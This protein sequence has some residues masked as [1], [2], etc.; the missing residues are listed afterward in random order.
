MSATLSAGIDSLVLKIKTPME[1][2]GVTPRDDLISAKVWYSTTSGFVPPGAG[3]LAYEGTGL[4]VSITGLT[5]GTDYYVRYALISEIQPETFTL[6]P[7]LTET[8]VYETQTVDLTPP[9]TPTGVVITAGVGTVFIKH[10]NPTYLMGRGHKKTH[11]FGLKSSPAQAAAGYTFANAAANGEIAQFTGNVFNFSSDPSTEWHIWLKWESNNGILSTIPS[12]GT[13]GS[14]AETAV[15]VS[16]LLQALTGEIS[17]SQLTAALSSSVGTI[18]NL[19]NQYTMKINTSG[20][21]AGFGLAGTTSASGNATSDFAV[22]ADK[23]WIAPPAFSSATAPSTNL[24]KGYIW[25]DTSVP[26]T[27]VTKYWTGTAWSLVAQ[28][29]TPFTVVTTP[30]TVGGQ[31]INPGVYIDTAYIKD[32]TITN[33]KIGDATITSAKIGSVDATTIT[34]NQLTSSQINS[35]GLSI[36]DTSGNLLLDASNSQLGVSLFVGTGGNQK[37]LS[38][39]AAYASTPNTAFIGEFAIAPT[40]TSTK[41]FTTYVSTAGVV[42]ITSTA[43]HGFVLGSKVTITA[44]AALAGVY[45]VIEIPSA[46]TFKILK[47]GQANGTVTGTT[48]TLNGFL[49]AENSVYKNTTDGNSYILTGSPLAWTSFISK[50]VNGDRGSAWAYLSGYTAWNAT[51]ETAVNTY[52]TNTYGGTKRI[53]DTVTVYGTNFSQTRVW[54]GTAWIQVT[55]A[56]DGNLLVKGTVAADAIAAG[57]ISVGLTIKST[58]NKFIV[59]FA[60]KFISITV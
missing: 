29:L 36:R 58:D 43:A 41:S 25:V 33:A 52:F 31:T 30:T 57:T 59:D 4:D 38:T 60:N 26:A 44:N 16:T 40:F 46:T 35:N 2:D 27:P 11:V 39:V 18:P 34:V 3:T 48:G 54:N 14:I 24:Y 55:V 45:D 7:E 49:Y 17:T 51:T 20:Q 50:G 28:T 6:S 21:I 5:S 42:T 9:P 1:A 37:L 47:I 19:N 10:D 32:G 22:Q 15:D 56:I 23:F 53:N 12:G 13:T 8:P